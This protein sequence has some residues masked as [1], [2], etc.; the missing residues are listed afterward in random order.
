MS[1]PCARLRPTTSSRHSIR[2]DLQLP[3]GT[4]HLPTQQTRAHRTLRSWDLNTSQALQPSPRN[5]GLPR[6]THSPWRVQQSSSRRNSPAS[7]FQSTDVS[8]T[9]SQNTSKDKHTLRKPPHQS[10]QGITSIPQRRNTSQSN[11]SAQQT[12]KTIGQLSIGAA[13]VTTGTQP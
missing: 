13:Q 1:V 12:E 10:T 11:S 6:H 4:R 9:T 3:V 8:R 7:V 5:T 2:Q